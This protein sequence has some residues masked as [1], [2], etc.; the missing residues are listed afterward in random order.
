M[1]KPE[2]AAIQTGVRLDP[3]TWRALRQMA[4]D[5]GVSAAQITRDIVNL[6]LGY[7]IHPK[8]PVYSEARLGG[9]IPGV[10]EVYPGYVESINI[11]ETPKAPRG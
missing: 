5:R 7:A 3:I 11:F 9:H 10:Q 4:L 1:S 2:S 8:D 6:Y